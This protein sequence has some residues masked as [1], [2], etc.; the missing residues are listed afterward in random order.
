MFFA[1]FCS[2]LS[3]EYTKM[4]LAATQLI[5]RS[6]YDMQMSWMS[7]FRDAFS[8]FSSPYNSFLFFR[9]SGS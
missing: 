5:S 8:F 6:S 7:I 9:E 2:N 4:Y 3:I 1:T